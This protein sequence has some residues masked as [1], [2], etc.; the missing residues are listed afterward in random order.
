MKG[1][2]YLDSQGVAHLDLKLDNLLLG[3]DLKLKIADFDCSYSKGDDKIT[4]LGTSNYRAPEITKQECSD[5]YA[6]D[7]YSAGICLFVLMTGN[8][9]YLEGAKI[10]GYELEKLLRT[11]PAQFWRAYNSYDSNTSFS[12]DF[13]NLFICMTKEDPVER[14]TIQK[15]MQS[16]W[17]RGEV[18]SESQCR[19][20][21]GANFNSINLL[22]IR[23]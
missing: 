10:A 22:K 21:I 3:Q 20:I 9:P 15:V 11:D 23:S 19:M 1:I 13:K 2:E 16:N 8:F 5:P 6:A 17:Y 7:I 12:E 4:S 18:Y 14:A